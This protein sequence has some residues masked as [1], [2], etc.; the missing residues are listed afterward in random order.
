M[1]DSKDLAGVERRDAKDIGANETEE[2]SE[3]TAAPP[4]VVPRPTLNHGVKLPEDEYVETENA[5]LPASPSSKPTKIL[6][7]HKLFW[8]SG[9]NVRI[10]LYRLDKNVFNNQVCVVAVDIDKGE[11]M[12]R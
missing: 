2:V 9:K 3:E 1:A 11:E 12:N 5:T 8:K 4:D 10:D 6:S 7:F